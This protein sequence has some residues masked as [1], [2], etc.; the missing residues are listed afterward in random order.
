MG[1]G[2]RWTPGR[3]RLRRGN[4]TSNTQYTMN[5]SDISR[6]L[7][8]QAWERA[9]GELKSMLLTFYSTHNA[10]EGQF[11]RLDAMVEELIKTVEDEGL[12][13]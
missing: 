4:F 1:F 3:G 5:E 6:I 2:I 9:K 11:D 8:G 13:E 10:N 12:H 7:R